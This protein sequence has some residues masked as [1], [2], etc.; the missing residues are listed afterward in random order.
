MSTVEHPR[1]RGLLHNKAFSWVVVAS[2]ARTIYTSGQVSINRETAAF[3][4]RSN[5]GPTT[6]SRATMYGDVQ[7]IFS[8][9]ARVASALAHRTAA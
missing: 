4:S 7:A 9:A 6:P 3:A 8:V 5:A 2:G 1:V